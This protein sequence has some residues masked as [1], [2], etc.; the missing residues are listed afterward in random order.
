MKRHPEAY[1]VWTHIDYQPAVQSFHP[2]ALLDHLSPDDQILDLGCNKG[3]VSQW[4][5][6]K[7]YRVTGLDINPAAIKF[8]R[9]QT[10]KARL[11]TRLEYFEADYLDVAHRQGFR[12]NAVLMI[13]LLTCIPGMEDWKRTL[14]QVK[15]DLLH[16]GI[17]Y[18]HDFLLAPEH[19]VYTNRYQD[20]LGKGSRY[21]NFR[22]LDEQGKLQF[23]AHHHSQQELNM[24]RE[25]YQQLYYEQH[26]SSSM[27][28]NPCLMFEYI[29]KKQ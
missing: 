24:I 10:E 8:A 17:L 11:T 21:G 25:G 5:A 22:V 18:V 4:L 26:P 7:G 15:S 9:K 19:S 13:R 28:G 2:T 3:F 29:G 6:E 27:N 1:Q 20:Y 23:V 12:Y 16:G 14:E